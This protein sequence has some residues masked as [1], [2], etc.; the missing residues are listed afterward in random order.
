MS[1][2]KTKPPTAEPIFD[3]L[4]DEPIADPLIEEPAADP[5]PDELTYVDIRVPLAPIAHHYATTHV[6]VRLDDV[7]KVLLER[8]FRG[9]RIEDHQLTRPFKK[10]DRPP[11]VLR[12][13]L[14]QVEKAEGA[15]A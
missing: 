1:K 10:V 15:T 8:I 9:L 2:K 5:L 14:E 13:L 12:F 11:D 6:E 3:P 4:T 7:Q